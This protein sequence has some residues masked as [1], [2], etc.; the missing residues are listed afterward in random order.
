M[1]TRPNFL[2]VGAAKSGTTSIANYLSQHPQVYI[3]PIKEPKFFSA[4]ENVF[5]HNGPGDKNVDKKVDT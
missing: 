2:I 5:P 1:A 3:S 4:D